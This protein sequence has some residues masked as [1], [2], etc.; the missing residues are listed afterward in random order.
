MKNL[1]ILLILFITMAFT[2]DKPAYLLYD[3]DGK[4]AKY[5]KMIEKLKKADVILFGE[6]HNNPIAH[7]LELELAKDLAENKKK[8]LILATEMFEADDQLIIDEYLSEQILDKHLEKEAK[9]WD[10]Y[11]TDYK[12]LML[13]AKEKNLKFIATN[14]PR[15][16]AS[17]VAREGLKKLNDLTPEAKNYIA[18]LPIEFDST[19]P[20]YANMFKM[21]GGSASH[22][23]KTEQIV[24]A[25]AIKDA[26]MAHNIVKNWKKKTTILHYNGSYHSDN[27][28]SIVWY[29]NKYNPKLKVM[30][31]STVLQDD[32]SKLDDKN[33]NV[34]D[35]IIVAPNSM[36]TT[37]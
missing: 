14:I 36:T 26:T 32:I 19:L 21:M 18:P 25:Q 28:E 35:Y 11:K 30:T 37:Y 1:S 13:L 31:L 16:Y 17:L 23:M 33:K 6:L 5:S 20:A 7:W 29:L 3:A 4:L 15:R 34:A 9:I 22:G 2:T 8:T 12:P 27:K 24:Q 10:N